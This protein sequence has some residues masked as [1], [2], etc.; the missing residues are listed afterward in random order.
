MSGRNAAREVLLTFLKT[1]PDLSNEIKARVEEKLT[2]ILEVFVT[3]EGQSE[4]YR[5][6]TKIRHGDWTSAETLLEAAIL[7]EEG[8]LQILELKSQCEKELKKNN[9]YIRTLNLMIERNPYST[10]LSEKLEEALSTTSLK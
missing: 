8:N 3:D 10:A 6:Q 9:E 2:G 4:Y 7:K 5:A 1:N